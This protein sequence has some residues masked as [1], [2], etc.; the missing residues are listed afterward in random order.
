MKDVRSTHV[1]CAEL[2][3]ALSLSQWQWLLPSVLANA[4]SQSPSQSE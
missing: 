4:P 2:A 3:N 1:S